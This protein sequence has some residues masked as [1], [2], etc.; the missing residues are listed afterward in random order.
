MSTIC[1]VQVDFLKLAKEF[2]G[3]WVALHPDTR[4]LVAV[5]QSAKE[6]LESALGKGVDEPVITRIVDDYG[7]Y[8][9]C[10]LVSI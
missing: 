3:R 6:V 10:A 9:P 8:I 4:E 5:G 1:E 7:A 2:A